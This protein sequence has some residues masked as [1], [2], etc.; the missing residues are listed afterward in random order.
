MTET[1]FKIHLKW[2]TDGTI[3]SISPFNGKYKSIY[4]RC[5]DCGR[6]WRTTPAHLLDR[7]QGC[8]SCNRRRMWEYKKNATVKKSV[9][10][11]I[12]KIFPQYYLP[13]FNESTTAQKDKM[14]V[15]CP[16]HGM[17]TT[18]IDSLL[19]NHG[20]PTCSYEKRGKSK[21]LTKEKFIEC[22]TIV[23][24][25]KYDYSKV[26]N[27]IRS[28]IKVPIICKRHGMFFQTPYHHAN[29]KQGCPSCNESSLELEIECI[30]DEGKI[31][32][33]KQKRMHWLGLQSLDFY[34]PSLKI[35]IECQ[36][37]QHYEPIELFG[38]KES[39]NAQVRRDEKKRELC[40]QNDVTMIYYTHYHD[41]TRYPNKTFNSASELF[42]YI[43]TIK[44]ESFIDEHLERYPK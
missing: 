32:Y 19:H 42:K 24:G 4:C 11:R 30:L 21:A 2:V 36:G 12:N 5:T 40:E 15:S 43:N 33:E 27:D 34:I 31:M 18:T 35:A 17:F 23:H 26:P 37:I 1:E 6:E 29:R 14:L 44:N 41:N 22:S 13:S 38:G 28:G 7:R 16:I 10:E 39:F 3:E 20:C 25:D 8:A 9:V